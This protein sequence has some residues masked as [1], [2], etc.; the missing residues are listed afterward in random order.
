MRAAW[1][2]SDM[3]RYLPSVRNAAK[4]K[5]GQVLLVD[6]DLENPKRLSTSTL[7]R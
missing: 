5:I 3:A 7:H 6:L 1:Q 2:R 4:A